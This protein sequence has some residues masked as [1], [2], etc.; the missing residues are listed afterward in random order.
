MSFSQRSSAAQI[1]A[2]SCNVGCSDSVT[3]LIHSSDIH[4]H[5]DP[6][7]NKA[8]AVKMIVE[9]GPW[10]RSNP[11]RVKLRRPARVAYG[12]P[13]L[14]LTHDYLVDFGL[15]EVERQLKPQENIYYRGYGGQPVLY[16]AVK[17]E[18]PEFLGVF[19]EADSMDELE[20]ASKIPGAGPV[21]DLKHP[22]GGKVVDII[23]PSGI[24]FHVIYGM[25]KRDFTPRFDEVQPQNY[26]A[27]EESDVAAKPRRGVFHSMSS[28]SAGVVPC[29]IF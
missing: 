27:T 2:Y 23:D 28:T 21:E 6:S 8:E 22:G 5:T 19:F 3:R 16:V 29:P 15:T 11:N 24:P 17:T 26:P 14:Y 7:F 4:Q 20:K 12:H 18:Q 9:D 13:D 10:A 25:S 1:L